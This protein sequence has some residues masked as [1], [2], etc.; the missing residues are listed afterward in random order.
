M[1]FL[2]MNGCSA[3]V[4]RLARKICTSIPILV[5][6]GIKN[7]ASPTFGVVPQSSD[8][9][10]GC[11]HLTKDLSLVKREA[12]Y[13]HVCLGVNPWL[14]RATTSNPQN[15]Q[16]KPQNTVTF[17]RVKTVLKVLVRATVRVEGEPS[18]VCG[19][20]FAMVLCLQANKH[21]RCAEC[22][23]RDLFPLEQPTW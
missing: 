1:I 12:E 4:I 16:G 6:I 18:P 11:T 2:L 13:C 9:L 14:V 8:S 5:C 3:Y 7:L 10:Q 22:S 20:G 21:W 19:T 23:L 15:I 17:T